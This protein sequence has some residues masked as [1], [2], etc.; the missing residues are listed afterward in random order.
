MPQAVTEKPDMYGKATEQNQPPTKRAITPTVA[1]NETTVSAN[2]VDLGGV[3]WAGALVTINFNPAP[4]IPGPYFWGGGMFSLRPQLQADS[5]GH[6]SISLPDNTTITPAG[7]TWQFVIAPNATMPA[8]IFNLMVA[9]SSMDISSVFT[10]QSYQVSLGIIQSLPLPRAYGDS[11][12][13]TPS[14]DGQ[15]Y[16]NT[17]LQLI[18]FWNGALNQWVDIP[19]G[20]ISILPNGT[21]LNNLPGTGFWWVND[22]ANA[23]ANIPPNAWS[24]AQ[25]PLM[26]FAVTWYSSYPELYFRMATE[27]DPSGFTPWSVI[28]MVD[29]SGTQNLDLNSVVTNGAWVLQN[30]TNNGPPQVTNSGGAY[31][32]VISSFGTQGEWTVFQRL[33]CPFDSNPYVFYTRIGIYP[34]GG[35]MGWSAWKMFTGT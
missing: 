13:A 15:I 1:A 24:I 4:N 25:F 16:F 34:A 5:N 31:L 28:P 8:V 30:I 21:N 29:N 7:S 26:Q 3:T 23:P 2:L 18:R 12:V 19:S 17:Q 14:N 27:F 20:D 11:F 10:A 22:P 9:G 33:M 35:S 6:F 32:E